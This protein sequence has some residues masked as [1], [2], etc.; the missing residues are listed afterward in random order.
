MVIMFLQLIESQSVLR[1]ITASIHKETY[2]VGPLKTGVLYT[3]MITR[4]KSI[5]IR[6]I[7]LKSF[8]SLQMLASYQTNKNN[9]NCNVINYR[10]FD[11]Q[12]LFEMPA[13]SIFKHSTITESEAKSSS[14]RGSITSSF[15]QASTP[16][17][18]GDERPKA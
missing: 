14:G 4:S 8:G 2:L 11:G 3:T 1:C 17:Y 15:V 18:S 9:N 16:S 6:K 12:R 7:L 13:I 5:E 10:V